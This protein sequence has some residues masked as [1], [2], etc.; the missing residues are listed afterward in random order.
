V[1]K[2]CYF[3]SRAFHRT[4]FGQR[5]FHRIAAHDYTAHLPRTWAFF[6]MDEHCGEWNTEIL[7]EKS[8]LSVSFHLL[9]FKKLYFFSYYKSCYN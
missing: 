1:K 8:F 3:S 7:H 2:D 6:K 9:P 4:F 5:Y